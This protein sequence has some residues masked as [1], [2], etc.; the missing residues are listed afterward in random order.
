M[1]DASAV[2]ILPA[3][4]TVD[5]TTTF[6]LTPGTATMSNAAT[7]QLIANLQPLSSADENNNPRV[8]TITA[9]TT[10]LQNLPASGTLTGTLTLTGGA[11]T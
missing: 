10:N 3:D 5:A 2:T 7:P 1:Q 6:D 11:C 4:M 8:G 9:A